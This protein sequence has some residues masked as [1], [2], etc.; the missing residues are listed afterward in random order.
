MASRESVFILCGLIYGYTLHRSRLRYILHLNYS[1]SNTFRMTV[2]YFYHFHV[3][4]FQT[5]RQINNTKNYKIGHKW[6]ICPV[7]LQLPQ[8][9]DYLVMS[10]Y[11][12]ML[13]NKTSLNKHHESLSAE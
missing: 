2:I 10:Y 8:I 3:V 5:C 12:E 7:S 6:Y 9:N 1:I 13:N 11:L 4:Q